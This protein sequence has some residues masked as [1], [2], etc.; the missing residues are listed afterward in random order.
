MAGLQYDPPEMM[1]S[2]RAWYVFDTPLDALVTTPDARIWSLWLVS[3]TWSTVA[4]VMIVIFPRRFLFV[5]KSAPVVRMP[6]Y[7]V[8]GT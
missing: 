5:T 1:I 4:S 3:T 2:L 8:R 6:S 7:T